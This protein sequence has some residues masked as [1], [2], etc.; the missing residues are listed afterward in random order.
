LDEITG[1]AG[2]V[3]SGLARAARLYARAVG[4]K[5]VDIQALAARLAEEG[6]RHRTAEEVHAYNLPGLVRWVLGKEAAPHPAQ[7]RLSAHSRMEL[8]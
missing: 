4:P 8:S 6:L 2:E 3:R 7:G 1:G 5:N